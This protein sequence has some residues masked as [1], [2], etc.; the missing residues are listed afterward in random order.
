[1]FR[2]PTREQLRNVLPHLVNRVRPTLELYDQ[3]PPE[4]IDLTVSVGEAAAARMTFLTYHFSYYS[5]ILPGGL[6][7]LK[8]VLTHIFL[9]CE[10]PR[11][12]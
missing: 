1:M 9:G 6:A 11:T 10:Y 5:S 7:F 2:V 3:C 12:T 4:L 8:Y